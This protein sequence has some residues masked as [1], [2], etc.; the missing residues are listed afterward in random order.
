VNCAN[1]SPA[2]LLRTVFLDVPPDTEIV[3]FS[4]IFI[5][6]VLAVPL[7]VFSFPFASVHK[8]VIWNFPKVVAAF[9]LYASTSASTLT[10]TD[11]PAFTLTSEKAS[12]HPAILSVSATSTSSMN[13]KKVILSLF[14]LV[15]VTVNLFKSISPFLAV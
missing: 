15:P 2:A 4:T 10:F 14:G 5:L 13:K 3:H 11:S 12:S 6:T 7:P 1:S 9:D 8:I